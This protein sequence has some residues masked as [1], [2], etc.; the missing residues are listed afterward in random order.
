MNLL[1]EELFRAR[2][3]DLLRDARGQRIARPAEPRRLRLRLPR[4]R[5]A[6]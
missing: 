3:A 5:D 2:Q 1:Y 6:R 4:T